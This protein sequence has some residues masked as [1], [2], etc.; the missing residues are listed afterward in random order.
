M[1]KGF[2]RRRKVFQMQQEMQKMVSDPEGS[3][4]KM[5]KPLLEEL[6]KAQKEL[7][8]ANYQQNRLSALICALIKQNGGSVTLKRK[9]TD[10]FAGQQ[11][12][13][14]HESLTTDDGVDPEVDI[15][16]TFEAKPVEQVQPV[17]PEDIQPPITVN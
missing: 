7:Q 8:T 17:P 4:Q 6:Q 12:T 11:L 14:L 10:Q 15:T 5:A 13:I 2:L 9:D 3:F 16:F 1:G